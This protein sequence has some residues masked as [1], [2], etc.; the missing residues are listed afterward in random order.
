MHQ[1]VPSVLRAD[2]APMTNMPAAGCED[3]ASEGRPTLC[4]PGGMG[5]ELAA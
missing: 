4:R 1:V 3:D 5:A 2:R